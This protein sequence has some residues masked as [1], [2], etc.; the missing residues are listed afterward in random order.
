MEKEGIGRPATYNQTVSTIYSRKYIEKEGKNII[1]TPLGRSVVDLLNKHFENI[2]DIR[3]TAQMEDNLD[4]IEYSGKDWK[5]VVSEFY[6]GFERELRL[7]LRDNSKVEKEPDEE[8]DIPCDK[9]GTKMVIKSGKFGKFLA[10]PNFP[11]CRNTKALEE[12]PV[13]VAKCPKCGKDVK[14]LKSKTGKVF[15]G[16]DGFPDCDFKSWDIPANEKCPNCNN[17][18]IV[19]LYSVS[20]VTSCKKCGFSHKEKIQKEKVENAK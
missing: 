16:C 1:S 14:K 2:M 9:C 12:P 11:K 4:E 17:D 10:C 20:K 13:V 7:A 5:K 19:K 15:Y 18:M 3:F 8:T 6:D